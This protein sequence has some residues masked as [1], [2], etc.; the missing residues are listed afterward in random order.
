VV[1]Y[2][3][4]SCASWLGQLAALAD[5]QQRVQRQAQREL[6]AAQALIQTRAE[7]LERD[8]LKWQTE[9]VRQQNELLQAQTRLEQAQVTHFPSFTAMNLSLMYFRCVSCA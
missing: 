4:S 2:L 8:Q 6:E 3:C 5:S 7:Q 9:C 1:A